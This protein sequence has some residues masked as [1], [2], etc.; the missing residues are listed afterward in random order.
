M[1]GVPK[2]VRYRNRQYLDWIAQ[3]PCIVC[4]YKPR[5]E[6]RSDPDNDW[7][8]PAH[9]GEGAKPDDTRAL[10]MCHPHHAMAHQIGE[11]TFAE[12][13]NLDYKELQIQHITRWLQV[14]E[15]SKF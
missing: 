5:S 10:P 6:Y 12:I 2:I 1:I 14:T 11:K 15:Q 9:I 13:H 4:G 7:N 3:Q 8:D